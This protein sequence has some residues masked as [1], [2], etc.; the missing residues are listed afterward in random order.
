MNEATT[1]ERDAIWQR[2]DR[3][4]IGLVREGRHHLTAGRDEPGRRPPLV[5][6]YAPRGT[7]TVRARHGSV[8]IAAGELCV[9]TGDELV[10]DAVATD[11]VILILP[12]AAVGAGRDP[13][14]PGGGHVWRA[15]GGTASLVAHLLDGLASQLGTYRPAN[16]GRL[17]HHITGLVSVLCTDTGPISRRSSFRLDLALAAKDYI[18]EHLAEVDLTPTRIAAAQNVSTRSLHRLFELEG[19]TVASWIRQRRL[20]HCRLELE[21]HAFDNHSVSEIGAKWGLWDAAYFSR[22]FKSAYGLPPRAYRVAN[23]TRALTAASA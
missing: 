9:L 19:T 15:A 14:Q 1:L 13:F 12:D 18:E 20:E 21:E 7:A 5:V 2:Y 22:V 23:R 10:M 8:E 3:M 17:A 4:T 6:V 16:P 11:L